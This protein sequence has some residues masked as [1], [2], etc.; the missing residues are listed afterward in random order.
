VIGSAN[1]TLLVALWCTSATATVA[2]H[3]RQETPPSAPAA[4]PAAA[5][6]KL[7]CAEAEAVLA[8][9]ATRREGATPDA[10]AWEKLFATDGYVRLRRREKEMGQPFSDAEFRA[11][12]ESPELA[13]RADALAT[14]LAR[15]KEADRER[16]CR[17]ALAYL[18]PAARLRARVLLMIKPLPNSFVFETDRDPAIFFSLDPATSRAKF[19][20][21]LAHELHHIGF[22]SCCP[23]AEAT[24]A[25]DNLRLRTGEAYR[26]IGAFGEGFAMLAAAGGPDVHPHAVSTEEE[27]KRWDRD[28]ARFDDDL[29]KVERFFLDVLEGRL[30]GDAVSSRAFEFFGV[31]GPWYTVGWRMAVTIERTKGRDAL[32]A[33]LLDPRKLLPTF[34]EAAD[35][36]AAAGEPKLATWSEKLLATLAR[37]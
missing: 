6:L 31:Q 13:A 37:E 10:A 2:A 18:P 34:N 11:F 27:R 20:N 17:L 22:A 9:V 29:R 36:L 23:S 35:L 12:V 14:T 25:I 15:W 28:V 24:A 1:R 4:V 5:D 8:I 16:A 19:E 3:A 7:D 33:C 21:T 30:Q 26:W 32:L